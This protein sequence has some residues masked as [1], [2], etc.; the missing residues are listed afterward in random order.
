MHKKLLT[1]SFVLSLFTHSARAHDGHG[2]GLS[3]WHATDTLGFVVVAAL[4][5]AAIYFGK[6]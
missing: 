1:F 5:A 6:K 4:L 3:H 2:L